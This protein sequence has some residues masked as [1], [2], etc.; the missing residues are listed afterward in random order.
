MADADGNDILPAMLNYPL[1][2]TL[3]D[4]LHGGHQTDELGYRIQDMMQVVKRPYLMPTFLD[5]HDVDRFLADGSMAGL[6]QGLVLIMTL[7]GIPVNYYGTGQAFNVQRGAMFA[8]G[9]ASGDQHHFDTSAPLYRFIA[10]LP[11][12]ASRTSVFARRTGD[13]RSEQRRPR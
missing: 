3:G 4:V 9:Y 1:Y 12:C 10:Q 8:G 2:G 6:Q 11:I 7:P 13:P 5:N